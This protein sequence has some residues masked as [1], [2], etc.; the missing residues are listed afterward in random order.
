M[1]PWQWCSCILPASGW[2]E[3]PSPSASSY[4]SFEMQP[5]VALFETLF[6]KQGVA[7]QLKLGSSSEPRSQTLLSK[8]L[9][10]TLT[11]KQT[12]M[13]YRVTEFLVRTMKKNEAW[14]KGEKLTR[15]TN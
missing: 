5:V 14:V 10:G 4:L 15:I 11:D 8:Q 3:L 13:H 6:P 1:R 12:N 9:Q 7:V 2:D